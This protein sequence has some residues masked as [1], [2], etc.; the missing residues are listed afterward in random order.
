MPKF[1]KS[2]IITMKNVPTTADSAR[3]MLMGQNIVVQWSDFKRN[4]Y[5]DVPSGLRPWFLPN[6]DP[7]D[8]FFWYERKFPILSNVVFLLT[9]LN[10]YWYKMIKYTKKMITKSLF[11]KVF[12]SQNYF[13][14]VTNIKIYTLPYVNFQSINKIKVYEIKMSQTLNIFSWYVINL[15]ISL[16]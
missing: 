16:L 11:L 4:M 5:F 8:P 10:H 9:K 15:K 14:L 3:K 2:A 7:Q 13:K 1:N 6:L 12:G